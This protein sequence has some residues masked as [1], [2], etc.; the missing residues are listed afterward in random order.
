MTDTIAMMTGMKTTGTTWT[1]I[2]TIVEAD[3]AD[4]MGS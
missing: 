4:P 2:R 1:A 3:A